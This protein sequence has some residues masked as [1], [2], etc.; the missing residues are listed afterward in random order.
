MLPCA[1]DANTAMPPSSTKIG[2]PRT[3]ATTT[4]VSQGHIAWPSNAAARSC[5]TMPATMPRAAI[6]RPIQCGDARQTRRSAIS[7]NPIGS[8]RSATQ[9][10]IAHG[11]HVAGVAVAPH[12]R[13]AA[14]DEHR[15]DGR[16]DRRGDDMRELTDPALGQELAGREREELAFARGDGRA[17]QPDPE[18]QVLGDRPRS[19][20]A[21]AQELPGKDLG[22]RQ[23]HDAAESE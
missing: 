21:A 14:E 19:G 1:S 10:G 20:D 2:A 23:H 9:V 12:Q 15:R 4:I 7:A 11:D 18:G 8:A 22:K 3:A 17:E 16:A 6:A 5:M 13:N